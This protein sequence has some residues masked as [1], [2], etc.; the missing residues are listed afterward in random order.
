[1]PQDVAYT[2]ISYDKQGRIKQVTG[3]G[4]KD[5]YYY[6]SDGMLTKTKYILSGHQQSVTTIETDEKGR[7]I[8]E[9]TDNKN[10]TISDGTYKYKGQRLIKSHHTTNIV[11]FPPSDHILKY[12]SSNRLKTVT[13]KDLDSGEIIIKS[14]LAYD[15]QGRVKSVYEDRGVD[16]VYNNELFFDEDGYLDR[17]SRQQVGK[18]YTM[19]IQLYYENVK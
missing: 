7:I 13:N 4:T 12:D 11:T 18:D 14:T 1:M 8:K 2:H 16:W 19:E 3:D 10:G 9:H 17:I 6:D 15:D 5:V